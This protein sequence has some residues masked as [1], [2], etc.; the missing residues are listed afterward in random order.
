MFVTCKRQWLTEKVKIATQ[1][2]PAHPVKEFIDGEEFHLYGASYRLQLV[3]HVPAGVEQLPAFAPEGI[4]YVRRQSLA[5]TRQV[6]IGL[7][8][9]IGL[10][11]LQQHGRQYELDGQISNLTYDAPLTG[12]ELPQPREREVVL[13]AQLP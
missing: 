10:V 9:K 1:L 12:F 7:Y 13:H 6:I 5:Q 8:R 11:W 4:L 2:A 3:D